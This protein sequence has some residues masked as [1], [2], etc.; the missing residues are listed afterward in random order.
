MFFDSRCFARIYLVTFW[1]LWLGLAW[2]L[3]GFL[4]AV[5]VE[6]T[7]VLLF[8]AGWMSLVL[9]IAAS[10]AGAYR[11]L[12]K[13]GWTRYD[14]WMHAGPNSVPSVRLYRDYRALLHG[15]H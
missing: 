15:T 4:I 12:R 8:L 3:G 9:S 6:R 1:M 5:M 10:N 14:A 7:F 13:L 11:E 2:C